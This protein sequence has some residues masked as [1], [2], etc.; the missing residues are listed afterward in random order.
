[1]QSKPPFDID[2]AQELLSPLLG[3]LDTAL[4]TLNGERMGFMIVMWTESHDLA[5][6]NVDLPTAVPADRKSVV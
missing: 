5:L 2:K 1:M 4:E 3:Q 6:G